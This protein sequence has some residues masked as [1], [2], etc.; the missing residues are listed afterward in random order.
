MGVMLRLVLLRIYHQ[1]EV[2]MD[3]RRTLLHV[4]THGYPIVQQLHRFMIAVSRVSVNHDGR[5]GTAPDP[6]SGTK[7]VG[8]T[9]A[10]L[11]FGLTLTLLFRVAVSLVR[12]LLPGPTASASFA[13]LSPSWAPCIGLLVRRSWV[14]SVF[15]I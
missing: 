6:L 4:R 7:G 2:V 10:K 9:S 8:A 13:G 11:K 12:I 15:P 1:S 5:G 3:I 14:T